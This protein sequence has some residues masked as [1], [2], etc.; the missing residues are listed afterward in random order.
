[1]PSNNLGIIMILLLNRLH[2]IDIIF[3]T[4]KIY[5]IEIRN[6]NTLFSLLV[7]KYYYFMIHY[8]QENYYSPYREVIVDGKKKITPHGHIEERLKTIRKFEGV[9]A[10]QPR[11][12]LRIDANDFDVDG[13]ISKKLFNTLRIYINNILHDK[14]INDNNEIFLII[15][16]LN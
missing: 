13:I 5:A 15:L 9:R 14:I 8:L 11:K 10:R 12:K 7:E 1:M 3:D 2:K 4:K 6:L 16:D